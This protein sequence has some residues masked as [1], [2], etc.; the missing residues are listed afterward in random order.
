MK[1]YHLKYEIIEYPIIYLMNDKVE[2][3]YD[4][5]KNMKMPLYFNILFYINTISQKLFSNSFDSQYIIDVS[6]KAVS[7]NALINYKKNLI[8]F[9]IDHYLLSLFYY[10]V[11]EKDI[12]LKTYLKYFEPKIENKD[13]TGKTIA[14]SLLFAEMFKSFNYFK[15]ISFLKGILSEKEFNQN[16]NIIKIFEY[17]SNIN[18]NK[19]YLK[20]NNIILNDDK[21][22]EDS[23]IKPSL[24]TSIILL[25]R[26]LPYVLIYMNDMNEL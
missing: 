25:K 17:F 21:N 7:K 5:N 10:G 3:T 15:D 8:L 26:A 24:M 18:K 20:E 11:N 6:K 23:F 19:F 2:S 14:L 4:E 12:L 1:F 16:I 13:F 22:N 9:D